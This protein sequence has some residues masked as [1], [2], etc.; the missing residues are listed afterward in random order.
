MNSGKFSLANLF[1]PPAS[2]SY[3]LPFLLQRFCEEPK[4]IRYKKRKKSQNGKRE[5]LNNGQRQ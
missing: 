2:S 1:E 3:A 5:R 4:L